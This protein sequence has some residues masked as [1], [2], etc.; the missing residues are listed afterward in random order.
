MSG[1]WSKLRES[2]KAKDRDLDA[3]F[4]KFLN[5]VS[6]LISCAKK[7]NKVTEA[8]KIFTVY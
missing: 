4:E 3:E 7:H 6:C 8:K 1:Q 5:E 2:Y